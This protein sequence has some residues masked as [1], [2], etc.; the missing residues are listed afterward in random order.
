MSETVHRLSINGREFILIGTAHVSRESVDEVSRIITEEHP[1]RVCVEIDASR[2]RAMS[3]G[4][5][6]SSLDIYQVL[7]RQQGFLMLANLVLSSFQKRL[8]ADLG[9][10]PGEEMLA[11]VETAKSL[12]IPFSFC[13]RE[14]QV[15]LRRAWA[16]SGFW[17]KNKMLAALLSSAVTTEKLAPEQIE[18]LKKKSALEGMMEELAEFL[19][20]VKRVLIDERD[21]Y[22]ATKIFETTEEKVVAVVGA[23]HLQGIIRWM[24]ALA[25]GT[26]RSDL[27]GIEEIPPKRPISK[28]IPWLIPALIVGFVAAGFFRSGWQVTLN[29][30]V[31]WALVNGTLAAIGS[32]I[33]LAHPVTILGAFVTAP[34][35]SM[36]P[37]IGVGMVTGLLEAWFKKPRVKDFESLQDDILTVK[38]FFKNRF[39]HILLVFLLSSV[40]GMIGNLVGIPLLSSLLA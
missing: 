31:L 37:A 40:G 14:I 21:Q 16:K 23:G 10:K 19:P 26:S 5:N 24:N 32:L 11:A 15:T 4:Q 13:D 7:K 34:L 30:V 35:T 22:L 2:F 29:M 38:G 1:G 18:E 3:E 12:D 33:A 28:F 17:G 20:S 6:W 39:T 36:H 8:G 27:S 9:V 25:E